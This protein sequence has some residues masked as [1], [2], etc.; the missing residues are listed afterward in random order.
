MM[1]PVLI[2][3]KK[4]KYPLN[5]MATD[6]SIVKT[7]IENIDLPEDQTSVAAAEEDINL[8]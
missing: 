1:Q 8:I 5:Q 4:H 7:V 6:P 2:A 3:K